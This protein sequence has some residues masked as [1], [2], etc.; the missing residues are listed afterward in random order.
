MPDRTLVL[1]LSGSAEWVWAILRYYAV[2]WGYMTL[3]EIVSRYSK[4]ER[5]PTFV[6]KV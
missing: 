6:E 2:N 4:G 1:R 5:F 3:G